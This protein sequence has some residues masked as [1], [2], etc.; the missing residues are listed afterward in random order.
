[1][2]RKVPAIAC[3]QYF[4]IAQK[5]PAIFYVS[6]FHGVHTPFVAQ[7]STVLYLQIIARVISQVLWPKKKCALYSTIYSK[8]RQSTN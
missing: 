7:T 8:I 6:L 5:Q 3:K 4:S 2:K 1:M